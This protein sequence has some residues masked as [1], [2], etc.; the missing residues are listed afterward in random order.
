MAFNPAPNSWLPSWSEDGT[1]ISLPIASVPKLTAAEA[2]GA[3]GDIRKTLYALLDKISAHWD[4]LAEADR[5]QKMRIVKGESLSAGVI[6]TTY[7]FTFL[8]EPSS[9]EVVAE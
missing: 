2:D 9:V 8:T 5:P 3:T 1:D 4:S 7:Y 6:T